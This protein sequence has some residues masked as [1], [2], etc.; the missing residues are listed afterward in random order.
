VTVI[1]NLDVQAD[2]TT[3]QLR[4]IAAVVGSS[5]CYGLNPGV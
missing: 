1:E 2:P 3:L 5:S 4:L